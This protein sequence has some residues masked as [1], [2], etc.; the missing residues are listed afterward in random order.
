MKDKYKILYSLSEFMQGSMVK[1]VCHFVEG[2]NKDI[3]EPEICAEAIDDEAADAI[4]A[5]NVPYYVSPLYPPRTLKLASIS[6]FLMSPLFM[7]KKHYDIIHSLHYS[8][9]CFEPLIIKLSGKTKYVYTKSNLQWDNHRI[10]WVLKSK[11]S[12]RIIAQ[13]GS[14]LDLLYEKGFKNKTTLV[15]NGVDCA[16]YTPLSEEMRF[17]ARKNAQIDDDVFVFGYAAHFIEVKD[18]ITLLK[19]I[20]KLKAE[21]PKMILLL[22]GGAHDEVYHRNVMDYIKQNDLT[23][24][25]KVMGTISDMKRF[26]A[27][28]DCLVF[29]SKF[30][31]FSTVILEALSSGLPIIASRRGGNI[32]QVDDDKNG[33]LVNPEDSTA[34]A[35]AMKIYLNNPDLVK[36]HGRASRELALKK[37][38]V[39]VAV[40]KVQELYLELLE[41]S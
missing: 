13:A 35:D 3:F 5:L 27:M 29:P 2:L 17:S 15:Y 30:E 7:R 26:Y 11:L 36:S 12:D 10:N 20:T 14:G 16:D 37:Y 24:D 34:F 32:E 33:F 19:A 6:K 1:H 38:S 18:H 25:V 31:N 21:Y 9:L 40:R 22:C 4:R 39:E 41:N 28:C 23:D 8:S